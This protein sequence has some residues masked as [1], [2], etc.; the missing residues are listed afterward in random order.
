LGQH[1]EEILVKRLKLSIDKS[2]NIGRSN[3]K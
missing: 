3:E 1:T 2:Q